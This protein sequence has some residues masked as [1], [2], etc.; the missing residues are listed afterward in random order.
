MLARTP[1]AALR[2]FATKSG[3]WLPTATS[4]QTDVVHAA[5]S[6]EPATGAILTPLFLS[7]TF[8]QESVDKYLEKG[9]SYSRTNNP[10]VTVY[11]NKVAQLEGGVAAHVFGTGM[12]ATTSVVNATMKA[13][14]H[15][16]I[17]DCS[18]G[19][20]NRLMR[21]Q[22]AP[23]DMEFSFV[24]F[25]DVNTVKAAIKPNTKLIF[26]ETP[27]NPQLRLVDL[28]A[29]SKLAKE[30][31]AVHACDSTFATPVILRPLDHGV[32]L[33]IQSLTKFYEGHNICTGGA[34]VSKT[35][36]LAERIG[37]VQNMNGNI[38]NPFAAFIQMQT[39]KTMD[40]R[41]RKQSDSAMK[42]AT[43]LE[44]HP[45]VTKCMYPGLASFPQKDLADKYHRE[46]LHGAMLWFDV[47][48]G[49]QA[50]TKLM[51]TC[52]RPWSLCENLGAT[53]SI[54]TACAVMTHANMLT[55]DRLKVGITDGF[56]RISVGIE[57]PD[58]LIRSLKD[59][60]DNL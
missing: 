3:E 54:I 59:A 51:N 55:E 22:F 23:F 53:E 27:T 33:T 1:R 44:S 43:F 45:K 48:G 24:D 58:D 49:S 57:D 47:E 20:T 41:V 60:L 26:S 18:Y 8:V 50:G 2:S 14:D 5:V 25:R 4:F 35:T 42:I 7:T 29:V 13:G 19:G 31:G 28:E 16:V 46:G 9:Y 21:V 15:C 56:I 40:L 10:T 36:E 38:M 11:Q 37:L 52:T 34:V 17:S 12:A 32:D 39:A 30:I 6:P